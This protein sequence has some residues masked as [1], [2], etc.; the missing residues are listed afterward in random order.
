MKGVIYIFL[1][2]I[3]FMLILFVPFELPET[4]EIEG[5]VSIPSVPD[6]NLSETYPEHPKTLKDCENTSKRDFCVGDMAEITDNIDLCYEINDPDIRV[7]CIARMSLNKTMCNEVGEEGLRGACLESINLKETWS[8]PEYEEVPSPDCMIEHGNGECVDGF[9][10]I[11]FYNPNQQ[12]ITRIRIT[13]P[14]GVQ[15]NITLPADFTVSEPLNLGKTGVLTLFPCEGDVDIS[16]FS[17]EWCCGGGCYRSKMN[18]SN[19]KV[20]LNY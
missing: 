17:M 11:P 3:A 1:A 6:E 5:N 18:R 2:I 14:F 19:N 4:G 15:T 10:R 20:E 16:V 7:F 12:D 8:S 9:L 13:V